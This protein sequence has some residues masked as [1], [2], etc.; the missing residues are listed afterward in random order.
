M[1]KNYDCFYCNDLS[2]IDEVYFVINVYK[3]K[4]SFNLID[5]EVIGW[6]G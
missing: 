1:L 2:D 6:R 3:K 4:I 5:W